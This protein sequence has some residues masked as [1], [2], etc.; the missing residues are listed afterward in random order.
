MS[1]GKW[2]LAS[3]E[4]KPR[5]GQE[6]TQSEGWCLASDLGV[7]GH[8]ESCDY[9]ESSPAPSPCRFCDL[10]LLYYPVRSFTR[11]LEQPRQQIRQ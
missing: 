5:H 1:I 9:S 11:R 10:D 3:R 6:D 8:L 2:S 7:G 4:G